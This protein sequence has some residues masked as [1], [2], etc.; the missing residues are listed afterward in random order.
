MTQRRYA[1][2]RDAAEYFGCSERTI[3]RSISAGTLTGYRIG[4]RLLRVDLNEL[5]A[6]LRPI[7]SAKAG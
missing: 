4:K 3:R 6:A 5:D 2:V 1:S 7:P